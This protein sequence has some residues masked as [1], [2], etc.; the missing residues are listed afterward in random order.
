[1]FPSLFPLLLRVWTITAYFWK[2]YPEKKKRLLYS[3]QTFQKHTSTGHTTSASNSTP[4][5]RYY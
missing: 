5:N 3:T 1:M 4:G 2:N